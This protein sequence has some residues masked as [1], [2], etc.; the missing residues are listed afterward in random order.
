MSLNKPSLHQSIDQF[1]RAMMPYLESLSDFPNCRFP[2]LWQP[3]DCKQQLMLLRLQIS[4]IGCFFTKAENAANLIAELCQ[5]LI[6]SER[7]ALFIHTSSLLPLCE[8]LLV[9]VARYFNEVNDEN[10][11]WFEKP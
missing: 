1:N 9:I 11:Y 7:N 3:L 10:A 8:A 5:S 2:S 6:L 4:C